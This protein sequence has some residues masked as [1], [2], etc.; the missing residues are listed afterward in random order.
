MLVPF[1]VKIDEADV[2]E[3]LPEKL[4]AERH[5]IFAW[6]VRGCLDYLRGGLRQP[7][8]VRSATEEY[9]TDSDPMRVFLLNECEITGN[10]DDFEKG[11]DLCDALNAYLLS[12]GEAAWGKRTVAKGLKARSGAMKGPGGHVFTPAKVSDTGYRGLKLSQAAMD[13]IAAHGD[14]LRAAASRRG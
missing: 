6:M 4:W 12:S 13:R 10:P 11:R 5:G 1:A 7:D 3:A 2:D 14:E 9:R 8:A